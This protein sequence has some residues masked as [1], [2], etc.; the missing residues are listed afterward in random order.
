MAHE[1]IQLRHPEGK[2]A[3]SIE[4]VRYELVRTLLLEAVPAKEPGITRVDLRAAV[5]KSSGRNSRAATTGGTST[6]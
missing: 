1:R 4:R 2:R 3:P 6:G 5:D